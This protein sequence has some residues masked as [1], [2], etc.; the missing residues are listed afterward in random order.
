MRCTTLLLISG[1]CVF[2]SRCNSS[3]LCCSSAIVLFALSSSSGSQKAGTESAPPE[4][5][6]RTRTKFTLFRRRLAEHERYWP[7]SIHSHQLQRP[8]KPCK[9]A[10]GGTLS[11]ETPPGQRAW[12]AAHLQ[13]FAI[14]VFNPASQAVCERWMRFQLVGC[15]A[16]PTWFAIDHALLGRSLLR[17]AQGP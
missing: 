3:I 2:F 13:F 5:L 7:Q 8:P 10:A 17:R 1:G 16:C 6:S 11:E 9:V 15:G 14:S 4:S 12:Q